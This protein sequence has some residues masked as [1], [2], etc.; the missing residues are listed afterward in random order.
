MLIHSPDSSSPLPLPNWIISICK[1]TYILD[2]YYIKENKFQVIHVMLVMKLG[3][4]LNAI[5]LKKSDCDW[6]LLRIFESSARR[7]YKVW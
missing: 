4:K 2:G 3:T 5:K 6:F 1:E 7:D